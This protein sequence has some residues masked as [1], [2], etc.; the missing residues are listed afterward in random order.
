MLFRSGTTTPN[1][2]RTT[3]YDANSLDYNVVVLEDCCSS[4]TKEIQEMNIADMARM[5]AIIIDHV[6]FREYT[7]DTV[8]NEKEVIA[9]E[10]QET[11]LSPEPFGETEGIVGWL[12]RW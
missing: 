9:R 7:E 5:G 12:D 4:Q 2:I 1:C 3:C 10:I 6:Q 8:G 11:E